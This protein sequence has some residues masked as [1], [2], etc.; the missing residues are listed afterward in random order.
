[1]AARGMNSA[2]ENGHLEVFKWAKWARTNGCPWSEF[3]CSQAAENGH[4]EV[5]K[6]ARANGARGIN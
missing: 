1:M 5:L 2:D 4:L 3:T 6:W